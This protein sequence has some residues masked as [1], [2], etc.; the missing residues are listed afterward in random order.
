MRFILTTLY[1][2]LCGKAAC[3]E[4][5]CFLNSH[6]TSDLDNRL[7]SIVLKA[8][9]VLLAFVC[10]GWKVSSYFL[11]SFFLLSVKTCPCPPPPFITKYENEC[12]LLKYPALLLTMTIFATYPVS[13]TMASYACLY[14]VANLVQQKVTDREGKKTL[15][16]LDFKEA[17]RFMLYGSLC[18]APLVH[19]GLKMVAYFFPGTTVKQLCKKVRI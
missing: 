19:N 1:T 18:H 16:D 7:V 14:P 5:N 17:G 15:R 10:L 2:T 6:A 13:R 11:P 8:V 4:Q 3:T 9:S 12:M